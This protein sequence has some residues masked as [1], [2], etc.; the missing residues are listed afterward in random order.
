MVQFSVGLSSFGHGIGPTEVDPHLPEQVRD[1]TNPFLSS[2]LSIVPPFLKTRSVT[3][4]P[5][6]AVILVVNDFISSISYFSIESNNF[7]NYL[8]SNCWKK[9][10]IKICS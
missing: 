10:L 4:S 5:L 3:T 1:N 6:L 9:P 7:F 8:N 2:C